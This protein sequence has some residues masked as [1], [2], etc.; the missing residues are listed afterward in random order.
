MNQII[1]E[2]KAEYIRAQ[3]RLAK[4]IAATPDDKLKWSPAPTA[5]TPL[6]LLVHSAMGTSGLG[7]IIAGKPFPFPSFAEMDKV[8]RKSEKEFTTKEQGLKLLQENSQ[9]YL[10]WLDTLSEAQISS[11]IDFVG[12]PMPMKVAITIPA[13]HLRSHTAQIDYIQ[14]IYGDHEMHM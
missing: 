10:T 8:L 11:T 14:T 1:E 2:A 6:E 4:T 3:E 12:R 13:D 5:R 7:D 9:K